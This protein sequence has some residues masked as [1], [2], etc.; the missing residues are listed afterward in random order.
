MTLRDYEVIVIGGGISGAS[1]AFHAAN[2][3]RRVLVLEREAQAGGCLSSTRT[4]D[5]FWYELGGHTC[6]NSYGALLEVLEARGLLGA[7]QKRG[8]PV[9]RFLDGD[10]VVSGKN[11]LVLLKLFSKLELFAALPRW[12][13]AAQ[14]GATARDYYSRLVGRRNYER[15]LGPMLSAVPSQTADAFPADMLF[16]KRERREDVMRSY[17]LPGGL[18]GLVEGILEHERIETR[19]GAEVASIARADSGFAV[20]LTRGDEITSS[21]VATAV[22]P[23]ACTALL[24]DV[25]PTIAEQASRV[26]EAEVDALGCAVRASRVAL[27]YATF[28]IPLKDTFYSVVTRD[29]VPDDE[30]RG[31]TFH[32]RP[33]QTRDERVARAARVLG[34][35]PSDMESVSERSTVVPSPTIG[36]HEIVAAIDASLATSPLAVTGNW[37]AGLSIEDCVQRSRAEWQR[38]QAIT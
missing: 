18:R 7:L 23:T 16:K 12:I 30:W 1:F 20:K 19:T 34:V 28:F 32:F 31:F 2:A 4:D 33:G 26:A 25:A 27:P 14:Q 21:V 37:F 13:G 8:K 38:V 6:Y 15:V 5:G 11:L 29:V 17:T 22:S 3:G 10:D 9:L 24:A 35:S 36:H